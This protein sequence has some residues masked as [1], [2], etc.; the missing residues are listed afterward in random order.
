MAQ[1]FRHTPHGYAARF[2]KAEF[3]LIRDLAEDVDCSS[4]ISGFGK[5]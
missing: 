5:S 4:G 1:G 2:E 3:D